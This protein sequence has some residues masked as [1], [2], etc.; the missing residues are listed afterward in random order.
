[1]TLFSTV[2]TMVVNWQADWQITCYLPHN[3]NI[4]IANQGSLKQYNMNPVL[5]YQ[6]QLSKYQNDSEKYLCDYCGHLLGSKD[7]FRRHLMTTHHNKIT[8]HQYSFC[9]YSTARLDSISRHLKSKH[10]SK[11]VRDVTK[12][13]MDFLNSPRERPLS[14]H[15]HTRRTQVPEKAISTNKQCQRT[16]KC[17]LGYYTSLMHYWCLQKCINHIIYWS[18]NP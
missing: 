9:S 16:W 17:F 15:D 5:K 8:E 6:K 1:M 10:H 14:K 4:N 11:R 13:I 2:G 3:S 12:Y 7:T 18:R